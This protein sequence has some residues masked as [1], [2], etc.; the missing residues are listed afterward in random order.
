MTPGLGVALLWPFTSHRYV[1]AWRPLLP[2]A[3]IPRS[4]AAGKSILLATTELW[5]SAPV[6]AYSLWPRPRYGPMQS[7]GTEPPK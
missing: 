2:L 5:V 4:L 6:L 1:L 7:S 3:H